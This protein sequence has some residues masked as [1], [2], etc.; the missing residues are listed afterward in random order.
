MRSLK[1]NSYLFKKMEFDPRNNIVKLCIQGMGM[2]GKGKPEDASGLFL[3]A[4]NEAAN[5]FEKYI[6]A[7]FVARQQDNVAEQLK[8]LETALQFAL[9][10]NNVAASSAFPDLYSKIAKCYEVLGDAYNAK[11]NFEL[12]NSSA[13]N[14]SDKGP[15]I[16]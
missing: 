3:Q 14:P 4:W 2:E 16:T 9:R 6:A 8:W 7:Y 12:A 1:S 15:F 13:G 5:D 10:V 11:K